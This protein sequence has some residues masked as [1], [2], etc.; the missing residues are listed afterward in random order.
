MNNVLK[1]YQTFLICLAL[2]MATLAAYYQVFSCDFINYDDP[3][4]VYQN[5]FV[6]KGL[7][8]DGLVWASRTGFYANWHPLTWISHMIDCTIY[9]TNPAGHHLTNLLF[10]IANTLILFA[11]LK[12][13][14]A[15]TWQ[16]AFVAALFALHPLHVESVAWI[17]ERKD[18]LSTF[19]GLLT[20]AAYFRYVKKPEKI[21]YILALLIFIASL[22]AKPMLV[23]LP[24]ILILLDY[25]PLNRFDLLRKQNLTTSRIIYKLV[26]EKLP[27]FILSAI[28][29]LTT[30]LVQKASGAVAPVAAIPVNIRIANVFISYLKYITKMFWPQ[31][32]AI[33]YPHP[34]ENISYLSA[35]LSAVIII[36][37]SIAVILFAR[38]RKYL[39]TGWLWYIVTLIPVIGLVQAGS[40]QIADRYTY[41]PLTGLFIIIAWLI[42]DLI[43]KSR[44]KNTVLVL[45]AFITLAPLAAV[46]Y[47]QLRHWENSLTLFRHAL[48]V[49]ENNYQAHYNIAQALDSKGDSDNAII[50]LRKVIRIRP[51]PDS[52]N[53]LAAMLAIS[54]NSKYYNPKEAIIIALEICKFTNYK[55]SA[56]LDTLAAAYA[57]D[58]RFDLAV[59][60]IKKA[61]TLPPNPRYQISP[62]QLQQRLQSYQNSKIYY[63]SNTIEENN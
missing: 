15:K 32:L 40:Q 62:Q 44:R 33:Y 45:A 18:V 25:W 31:K 46:T 51:T 11:L 4:Y 41:I 38:R 24:I 16:S 28:S 59:T 27:F 48:D 34:V 39:L 55:N 53:T 42:P 43:G 49:T 19:F 10:H 35:V 52:L 3:E 37:V 8:H 56:Y 58:G 12:N 22:M 1:K 20:I 13:V 61:L 54:K 23:T 2:A 9:G 5:I 60:E 29:S 50:H 14:T 47:A 6:R 36:A 7:T 21:K 17:S 57:A 26:Y 63:D 30:F